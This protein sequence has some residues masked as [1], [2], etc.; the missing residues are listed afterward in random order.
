MLQR[1]FA[2]K[3]SGDCILAADEPVVLK[4][5]DLSSPEEV[6][7]DKGEDTVF[8]PF[9]LVTDDGLAIPAPFELVGPVEE[10]DPLLHHGRMAV[11]VDAQLTKVTEIE[12]FLLLAEIFLGAGL[13]AMDGRKGLSFLLH[14]MGRADPA[15]VVDMGVYAGYFQFI[16]AFFLAV[17]D[18]VELGYPAERLGRLPGVDIFIVSDDPDLIG[19]PG[20]G[21][22]IVIVVAPEMAVFEKDAF[23]GFVV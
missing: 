4:A 5:H 23:D 22:D 1:L 10:P 8:Q 2:Y 14:I 3:P 11:L 7:L 20:V 19:I 17:V 18:T 12:L 6:L 9:V 16:G 13:T 21:G 15:I